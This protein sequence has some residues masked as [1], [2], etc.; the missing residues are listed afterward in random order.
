MKRQVLAL[1]LLLPLLAPAAADQEFLYGGKITGQMVVDAVRHRKTGP[2]AT[3]FYEALGYLQGV[4]DTAKVE[5]CPPSWLAKEEIDGEI[6]G[7]LA[8]LGPAPLA[9][10]A[11]PLI[12]EAMRASFP[13]NARKDR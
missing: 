7:H 2:R 4:K 13:C 3:E 6:I 12:A 9:G 1:L 10:A 11:P 5:W 8:K